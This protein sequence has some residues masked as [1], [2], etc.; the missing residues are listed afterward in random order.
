MCWGMGITRRFRTNALLRSIYSEYLVRNK[1]TSPNP[2]I[3][4][5]PRVKD[6]DFVC[7]YRLR[8]WSFMWNDRVDGQDSRM[9]QSACHLEQLMER[10][11]MISVSVC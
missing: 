3:M 10:V 11:W 6:E 8:N 1:S 5:V 4:E 7:S 2:V 9:I